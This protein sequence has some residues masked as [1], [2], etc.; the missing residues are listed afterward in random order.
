M[1]ARISSRLESVS[2]QIT[3]TPPAISP[4][5]CSAKAAG[6]ADFLPHQSGSRRVELDHALLQVVQAEAQAIAAEGVGQ[7]HA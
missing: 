5:A 6:L 3:S 7:D 2:I 4:R 1:A